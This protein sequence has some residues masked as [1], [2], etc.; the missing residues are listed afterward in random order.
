[1]FTEDQVVNEVMDTLQGTCTY[2][3][4][5]EALPH[6]F[7]NLLAAPLANWYDIRK[8]IEEKAEELTTYWLVKG[9]E[10]RC[11]KVFAEQSFGLCPC[12]GW[13]SADIYYEHPDFEESV[14]DECGE[15]D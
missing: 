13:W 9:I 8:D 11:E 4:V 10:Q 14:C 12:C 5:E 1:M 7:F 2:S 6:A 15:E 3:S